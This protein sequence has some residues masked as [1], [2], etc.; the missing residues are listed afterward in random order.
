MEW[1]TFYPSQ[2]VLSGFVSHR[3][4][5]RLVSVSSLVVSNIR[6]DA[7]RRWVGGMLLA[8]LKDLDLSLKVDDWRLNHVEGHVEDFSIL[9]LPP[10]FL[11]PTST[12]HG[13]KRNRRELLGSLSPLKLNR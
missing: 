9:G 4:P 10:S 6:R 12:R 7:G 11:S 1:V 3:Q 2:S 5:C 8:T 13:G